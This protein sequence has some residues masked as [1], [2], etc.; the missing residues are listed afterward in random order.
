MQ[1]YHNFFF[2]HLAADK[3]LGCFKFW[4]LWVRLLWTFRYK[5]CVHTFLFLLVSLSLNLS[6]LP[7]LLERVKLFPEAPH[8]TFTYVS[9]A[10]PGPSLDPQSKHWIEKWG[11][12]EAVS[13][14]LWSWGLRVSWSKLPPQIQLEPYKHRKKGGMA[15]GYA[16]NHAC[17]LTLSMS[18][19]T[20]EYGSSIIY[21]LRQE[22]FLWHKAREQICCRQIFNSPRNKARREKNI[23]TNKK[24]PLDR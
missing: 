10:S 15:L 8:Q 22:P 3:H 14:H 24:K 7:S 19:F 5:L 23:K 18:I 17:F 1:A 13:S 11:H 21:K 6:H 2:I 9:L 20:T 4:L 16:V 12:L